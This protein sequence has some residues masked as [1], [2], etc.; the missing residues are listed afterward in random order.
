MTVKK[1]DAL[2][3]SGSAL[4]KHLASLPEKS[5][6]ALF[7]HACRYP[8]YDELV[9][10]LVDDF[11]VDPNQPCRMWSTPIA[12]SMYER[13]EQSLPLQLVARGL[14][15]QK[16]ARKLA[17]RPYTSLSDLEA[18]SSHGADLSDPSIFTYALQAG[19]KDL[20]RALIPLVKHSSDEL[21][22]VMNAPDYLLRSGRL[23][24]D[25]VLDIA[26]LLH[27]HFNQPFHFPGEA[28][29]RVAK[30]AIRTGSIG[31]RSLPG[32]HAGVWGANAVEVRT[33]LTHLTDTAMAAF[34]EKLLALPTFKSRYD[35]AGRLGRPLENLVI[36]HG[37]YKSAGVVADALAR[38]KLQNGGDLTR[39]LFQALN[40]FL[41]QVAQ[42]PFLERL[43]A[44]GLK[45]QPL[46]WASM[47]D[48]QYVSL[49]KVALDTFPIS[50]DD[51]KVALR[52]M[53][54]LN[55]SVNALPLLVTAAC[56]D[57]IPF[58]SFAA[59]LT[60]KVHSVGAEAV[61]AASPGILQK[62][63]EQLAKGGH[64]LWVCDAEHIRALRATGGNLKPG[65]PIEG[66]A[67]WPITHPDLHLT[68]CTSYAP[69]ALFEAGATLN[70]ADSS[71]RTPLHLVCQSIQ[72]GYGATEEAFNEQIL[73]LQTCLEHGLDVDARCEEVGTPRQLIAKNPRATAVVDQVLMSRA[74]VQQ[75]VSCSRPRLRRHAL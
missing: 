52:G 61:E 27:K 21:G 4:K 2:R 39:E 35:S 3:L 6:R 15:P 8:Y 63:D 72:H 57:G 50:A 37:L 65:R 19:N 64:S 31:Y 62:I 74:V 17:T 42:P 49:L 22:G 47:L 23:D 26:Q 73:F 59:P 25:A 41:P 1:F 68:R 10:A 12:L 58:D 75:N 29:L 7:S 33:K 36:E 34:L 71:G 40:T 69:L 54:S 16:A 44:A 30:G 48:N 43:K 38:M 53:Q 9:L 14:D 70:V 60:Q 66:N 56:R 11:G 67:R 32:L 13:G 5:R 45:P 20:I 55:C 51:M 24:L 18:L 28:L 46:A